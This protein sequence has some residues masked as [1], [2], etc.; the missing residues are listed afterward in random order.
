MAFRSKVLNKV[1]SNFTDII[2]SMA[3]LVE[4]N[5]PLYVIATTGV[6]VLRL[7]N[8][9]SE[10]LPQLQDELE[11]EDKDEI[12]RIFMSFLNNIFLSLNQ[13]IA[14][15]RNSEID[16]LIWDEIKPLI[17]KNL[18]SLL[19]LGPNAIKKSLWAKLTC[20]FKK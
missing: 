5:D 9:I 2:S 19:E 6:I 13:N 4:N 11:T 10:I 15:F 14:I 18:Y 12:V 7:N 16:E 8:L 3:K 17:R 1:H 20:C